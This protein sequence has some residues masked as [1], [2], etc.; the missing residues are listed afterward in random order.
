MKKDLLLHAAELRQRDEPFALATVV[1][2]ERPTSARTGSRA[3][4]HPNGR[5]E[6]WIGGSCATP[7]VVREALRALADGRPRLVRLRGS[8]T[9]TAEVDD[10]VVDYPMTCHSGG[11]LEI[12]VEPHLPAPRLVVVGQSPVAQ[13]LVSLGSFLG[14]AVTAVA[15]EATPTDLPGADIIL[16]Q[17]DELA[18]RLDPATHLVIASFGEYDEQ[19]LEQTLEADL[20]YLALVA[21]PRRA[22]ALRDEL[23]ARGLPAA[24][25]ERIKAPAG[26]DLGAVE[27]EEIALS[28]MAEL[29]QLRRQ[30]AAE[31]GVHPAL[32]NQPE[33]VVRQAH[34]DREEPRILSLSKDPICGMS[35][36]IASAR[37]FADVH[38]QR[39]YFCCSACRQKYLHSQGY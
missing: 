23:R 6:G 20:A 32:P 7:I 14:F 29:V 10:T 22:A 17:I 15:P 5:L 24:S 2:C 16:Q 11:T 12:Y 39:I 19:V 1:R 21:S 9:A 30:P 38:G 35:V 33:P 26:L 8:E 18:G 37:H 25:I 4:I 36:E 28:I 27:P 31:E 13:A 3:L 34:H